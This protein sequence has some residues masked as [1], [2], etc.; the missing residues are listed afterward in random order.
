LIVILSTQFGNNDFSP[1]NC[2]I[3][4]DENNDGMESS[5][6]NYFRVKY[7][8]DWKEEEKYDFK[9]SEL[10]KEDPNSINKFNYN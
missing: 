2:V 9:F 5:I 7:P 8:T 6:G 3:G 1:R 10:E 4:W